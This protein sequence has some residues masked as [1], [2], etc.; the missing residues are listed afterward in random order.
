MPIGEQ[1]IIPSTRV[2]QTFQSFTLGRL[3]LGKR[4]SDV[5]LQ[6]KHGVIRRLL[7]I[8]AVIR[9]SIIDG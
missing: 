5:I 2:P 9:R 8:L 7:V 6:D 4:G 3:A 1:V